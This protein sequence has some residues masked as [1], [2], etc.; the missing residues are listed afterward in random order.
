MFPINLKLSGRKVVLLGAGRVGRR[1]LKKVLAAGARVLVVEPKPDEWLRRLAEAGEVEL[2]GSFEPAQLKGAVLLL[3]ASD[4]PLLNQRVACLARERGLWVNMA[5]DPAASDFTLPAL[6]EW[7]DFRLTVSSGGASP[8]LSAAVAERLR[9]S[10][11]PAYGALTALLS[12]IRP[13]VL[14]S[15]LSGPQREEVLRRLAVSGELL[16]RLERRDEGQARALALA[17]LAPLTPPPDFIHR[18][19][20][21]TASADDGLVKG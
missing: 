1:K 5:D 8:A 21:F 9:Q 15:S 20:L 18:R 17:L 4:D 12:E 19:T 13:L 3:T 10:F 14:A 11:G 7:G 6:V 16:K 2:Y